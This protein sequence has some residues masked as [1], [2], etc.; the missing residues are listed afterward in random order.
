[1]RSHVTLK[2]SWS[3]FTH[4]IEGGW[5]VLHPYCGSLLRFYPCLWNDRLIFDTLVRVLLKSDDDT[6]PAVAPTI[7]GVA[8]SRLCQQVAF[9]PG[10]VPAQERGLV[11]LSFLRYGRPNIHCGRYLIAYSSFT[12]STRKP[13]QSDI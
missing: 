10:Y 4:W 3:K 1:M 9:A 8:I 13:P 2:R 7:L 5:V 11:L 12:H 6:F